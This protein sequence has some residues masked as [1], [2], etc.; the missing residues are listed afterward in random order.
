MCAE[1]QPAWGSANQAP[2]TLSF[3]EHLSHHFISN[4]EKLKH[5]TEPLKP[6]G[7]W[8]T[9]KDRGAAVRPGSTHS[10]MS[11]AHREPLLG[12]TV[13]HLLH[14]AHAVLHDHIRAVLRKPQP[15]QDSTPGRTCPWGKLGRRPWKV[16]VGD[17]RQP[18]Q[19]RP[20]VAACL[21]PVGRGL[22][23]Q[24]CRAGQPRVRPKPLLLAVSP[25]CGQ[26]GATC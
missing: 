15:S 2:Q 14:A 12:H 3:K 10:P 7:L 6:L 17:H 26:R 9:W 16:L 19:E 5:R 1:G 21:R 13:Q 11:L 4:Q 24:G 8:V 23:A 22:E 25:P 20:E 18:I